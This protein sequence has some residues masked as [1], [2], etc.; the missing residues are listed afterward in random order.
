MVKKVAP[1]KRK[2]EPWALTA[3]LDMGGDLQFH[4]GPK[5]DFERDIEKTRLCNRVLHKFWIDGRIVKEEG[6]IEPIRVR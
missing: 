5:G 1:K 2:A 6:E 3:Y 4:G